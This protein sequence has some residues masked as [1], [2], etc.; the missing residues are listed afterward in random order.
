MTIR[1]GLWLAVS[2]DLFWMSSERSNVESADT[3]LQVGG[4]PLR[5]GGEAHLLQGSRLKA[6]ES[7][8][9][10]LIR[11]PKLIPIGHLSR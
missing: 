3:V 11:A 10:W 7:A 5:A 9:D 2:V 4:H 6:N 8:R 1:I